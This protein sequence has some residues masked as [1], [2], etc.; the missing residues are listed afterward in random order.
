MKLPACELIPCIS[1]FCLDEWQDIWDR[2][3]GN[4]L[5][6]IYPTVG[7]VKHSKNMSRYDSVPLNILRIG[8]RHSRLTHSYLLYGDDDH[9]TWY[10]N[11]VEFHLQANTY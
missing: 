5:H 7:I 1:K 6:S 11:L 8:I 9:P 2:C 10:E 4:K 3:D